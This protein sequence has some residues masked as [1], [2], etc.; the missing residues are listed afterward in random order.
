MNQSKAKTETDTLLSSLALVAPSIALAITWE[1]DELSKWDI[2][3]STLDP[4]DFE[5]WQSE[6]TA[7][8]IVDGKLA[9]GSDNLGGTWEKFGDHPS[10]SN[11]DISGYLPQMADEAYGELKH[12][13]P[14]TAHSLRAECELAQAYL[15]KWMRKSYEEQQRDI[16]TVFNHKPKERS[17]N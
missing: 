8:A 6:V 4:D 10:K 14:I 5:A 17:S 7:T 11:P 13:L 2:E 1:R 16:A 9:C 15:E 12:R 3:D